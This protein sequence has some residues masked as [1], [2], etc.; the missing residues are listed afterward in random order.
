MP[1][2]PSLR[3]YQRWFQARVLPR[4]APPAEERAWLNPQRGV[5]GAER[6]AVYAE[7]YLARTEEALAEVYEAVRQIVGPKTFAGVSRDYAARHPSHDYNLS[8]IGRHLP[9]FLATHAL[10][11]RL[12]FLPDLAQLEW[13][14][15]VAFHAVHAPPLDGA[16]WAALPLAAWAG[17]RVRFQPS[18]SLVRSAWP[19]LDLWQTRR[20]PR[21]TI[22]VD[23]RGRPQAVLVSRQG[24]TVRCEA[25]ADAPAR[26]LGALLEGR[27]LGAALGALEAAAETGPAQQWFAV[28]AG[29]GLIAGLELAEGHPP[30]AR[31]AG[32]C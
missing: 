23:L 20:Q 30:V 9:A 24:L 4:T 16:A 5:A 10:A 17:V 19:I 12:P 7:G 14:V 2:A 22:D 25:L 15:S 26:V 11:A 31:P 28:W 18:V 8:R 1:A 6:L 27:P 32:A 29:A 13:Q 21:A 3:E